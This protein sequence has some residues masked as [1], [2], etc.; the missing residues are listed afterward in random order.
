MQYFT[1]INNIPYY[2]WQTEI[3]IESFRM[4]GMEDQ[5]CIGIANPKSHALKEYTTNLRSHKNKF[6]FDGY[7]GHPGLGRIYATALAMKHGAIRVP[8]VL[9]D[10]DMIIR[11][12]IQNTEEDIVFHTSQEDQK[13]KEVLE[14]RI[15]RLLQECGIKR[16]RVGWMPVGHTVVFNRIDELLF[17]RALMWGERLVQEEGD[18]MDVERAAWIMAFHDFLLKHTYGNEF[19]E[20]SLLH[21]GVDAPFIHYDRGLPPDFV[22]RNFT[23]DG[24]AIGFLAAGGSPYNAIL[25]NNPTT[26]TNNLQEV[27]KSYLG[28]EDVRLAQKSIHDGSAV[29]GG[30]S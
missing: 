11:K 25:K 24:G 15:E 3:L 28:R 4:L 18:N 27:V 21:N 10:A 12:P 22:K 30:L 1:S 16:N 5:L 23:F 17:L 14:P 8:F 29:Q 7:T 26:A 19:F 9:I 20:L 6:F 13:L 2:H